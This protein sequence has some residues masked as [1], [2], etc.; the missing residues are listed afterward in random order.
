LN[1]YHEEADSGNPQAC[2]FLGKV[3]EEGAFLP[4]DLKKSMGYYQKGISGK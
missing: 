3:Y 4:I 2:A 1:I